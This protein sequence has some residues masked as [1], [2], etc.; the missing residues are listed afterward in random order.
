MP[1]SLG[2]ELLVPIGEK[3]QSASE[4][5]WTLW[6][7]ENFF[8]ILGIELWMSSPIGLHSKKIKMKI[9]KIVILCLVLCG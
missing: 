9:H 4:P 6:R 2:K 8:P 7:R 5:V 3:V 1:L